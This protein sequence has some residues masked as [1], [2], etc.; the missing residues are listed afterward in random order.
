[1]AEH[2]VTVQVN[3]PVHQVYNM[4]THFNDFPKF[5]HFVKEV[6]YYDE[7]RSHWVAQIVGKH[8]WDAVNE[9]WIADRQIGWRSIN[10]L[11]NRGKVTFQE[12]G[13]AQTLVDVFFYYNPPLGKLGDLAE[14]M[15]LNTRFDE[16][17]QHDLEHFARM[18]EQA[19]AHTDDPMAS[20]Y[21]FHSDSAVG[22][23]TATSQQQESM[24]RDTMMNSQ[25]LQEREQAIKQDLSS[26][27]AT[28]L[29][30]KKRQEQALAH[31]QQTAQAMREAL[32]RQQAID[33]QATASREAATIQPETHQPAGPQATIGGRGAPLPNTALGDMD[34][35]STR[36]PGYEQDEMKARRKV[37]SA[38][39]ET[40][41]VN[42]EVQQ[43]ED[44]SPWSTSKRSPEGD[45][46]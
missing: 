31:Q 13:N 9:E 18:V 10:G 29:E 33:Q 44:E 2:H 32:T 12:V 26:R 36:Y 11:E 4:F 38:S 39:K 43:A 20:R 42:P 14:N 41:I 23:E 45:E 1:M 28:R 24:A 7:Q 35:H 5:M 21:L 46:A 19:P 40:E 37:S 22:T 16:A 25:A 3:A 6:T 30:E 27:E 15:G 34:A 8:E 17:L